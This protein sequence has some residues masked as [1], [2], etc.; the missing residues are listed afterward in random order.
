MSAFV[1]GL[2]VLGPGLWDGAQALAALG[3]DAGLATDVRAPRVA[4]L[5]ANEARRCPLVARYALDVGQ[6]ALAAAGRDA[7]HLATV[8]SS[9]S[10]DLEIFDKNARALAQSPPALSPTL[11]HNSVHNAV[12]GYWGIAQGTRAASTSL[13][14]YDESFA[15]GVLEALMIVDRERQALLI[16]YDVPPPAA[17]AAARPITV[18]F[19]VA[20]LFTSED[21]SG[22]AARVAWRFGVEGEEVTRMPGALEALRL[23][24]PAARALPFLQTL[25]RRA[26][27]PLIL[28]YVGGRRLVLEVSHAR[29]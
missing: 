24:N 23:A 22:Q 27:R 17:L 12:A 14:A 3:Q 7:A 13:S 21:P 26:T 15:A 25:A 10:G 9:A 1:S 11:F 4:G 5:S 16:A 8:F 29:P 2:G 28:P 19:A 6:Q 18:P 20:V